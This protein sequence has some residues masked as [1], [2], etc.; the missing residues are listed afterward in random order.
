VSDYL[1][2]LVTDGLQVLQSRVPSGHKLIMTK[3]FNPARPILKFG[4]VEAKQV[5]A[6]NLY[7]GFI[8]FFKNP[9]SHKFLNVSDPLTVFEILSMANRLCA[10]IENA[11]KA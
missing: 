9:H 1:D 8:G 3:A 11:K 2:K 7:W 5:A 6:M 10:M 4:E